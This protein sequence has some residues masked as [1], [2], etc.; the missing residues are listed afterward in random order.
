MIVKRENLF[1][2]HTNMNIYKIYRH[3]LCYSIDSPEFL[4]KI[5]QALSYQIIN[6]SQLHITVLKLNMT[7]FFFTAVVLL[8]GRPE[9]NP[10]Y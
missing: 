10:V 6:N 4:N 8:A 1:N 7:Y 9:F 3:A 2:I 5:F